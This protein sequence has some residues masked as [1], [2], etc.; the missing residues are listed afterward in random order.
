MTKEWTVTYNKAK[1]VFKFDAAPTLDEFGALIMS[2]TELPPERQKIVMRGKT[3]ASDEDLKALFDKKKKAKFALYGTDAVAATAPKEKVLFIEDMTVEQR[4]EHKVTLPCGLENLGNTCFLNSTVQALRACPDFVA[5]I[6]KWKETAPPPAQNAIDPAPR[7]AH[8]FAGDIT[9]M[10]KTDDAYEPNAFVSTLRRVDP[11]FAETHPRNGAY[12]QHDADEFMVKLLQNLNK[13]VKVKDDDGKEVSIIDHY[14]KGQHEVKLTC[15]VEDAKEEPQTKHE[16]FVRAQCF[17]DRETVSLVQGIRKKQEEKIEK[18]SEVMGTDV[19][20]T[21]KRAISKLPKYLIVQ[22][23]RFYWKADISKSAKIRKKVAFPTRIDVKTICSEKLQE[24]IDV[25]RLGKEKIQEE[26]Q[27]AKEKALKAEA[28]KEKARAKAKWDKKMG[29]DAKGNK[30]KDGDKAMDVD[31]APSKDEKKDAQDSKDEEMKE[32]AKVEVIEKG[33]AVKIVR[34]AGPAFIVRKGDKV[35]IAEDPEPWTVDKVRAEEVTVDLKRGDHV[36]NALPNT[37]KPAAEASLGKPTGWYRIVGLVTH[38]GQSAG[39]G[40]YI[41]YGREPDKP[42]KG[43]Y[44]EKM[45]ARWLK[46][47]D[48]RTT[49][50]DDAHV[51]QLYGGTGDMQM[52]YLCVYAECEPWEEDSIRV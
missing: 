50:V 49:V 5:D 35:K 51:K 42:A 19:P 1:H 43:P 14:F 45:P 16:D 8:A 12:I 29:R 2:T 39:A 47:D 26:R 28:E 44:G 21:L 7:L 32:P 18:R 33:F 41:G 36:K 34:G 31:D 9:A 23:M 27:D 48:D 40:H 10:D 3:M 38:K 6:K 25:Y 30:M 37:L 46:F 11:Q 15:D 4:A 17:I 24:E 52:G 22:M 13:N 20:W